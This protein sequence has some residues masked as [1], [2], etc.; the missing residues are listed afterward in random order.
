MDS[1]S[2]E[3]DETIDTLR[4]SQNNHAQPSSSIGRHESST[5]ANIFTRSTTVDV[6][7]RP[8]AIVLTKKSVG[9]FAHHR[10]SAVFLSHQQFASTDSEDS[11]RS[12]STSSS[13]ATNQSDGPNRK[14]AASPDI[15]HHAP[16]SKRADTNFSLL[17]EPEHSALPVRKPAPYRVL[18][19]H[20]SYGSELSEASSTQY[21]TAE[22]VEVCGEEEP[23]EEFR[24][25]YREPSSSH[26][27]AYPPYPPFVHY[28][29]MPPPFQMPPDMWL[30]PPHGE[31]TQ[32]LPAG[33]PGG[34]H[35]CAAMVPM[36]DP[37]GWWVMMPY[38]G[39][40]SVHGADPS[41]GADTSAAAVPASESL[42]DAPRR[43]CPAKSNQLVRSASQLRRDRAHSQDSTPQTTKS[44]HPYGALDNQAERPVLPFHRA[45]P[46]SD[47]SPLDQ[48]MSHQPLRSQHLHGHDQTYDHSN[49][50]T[51]TS[52]SAGSLS[53]QCN[54]TPLHT[55]TS[56]AAALPS[57][58]EGT[59]IEIDFDAF[60]FSVGCT[61]QS[62]FKTGLS[63]IDGG[64]GSGSAGCEGNVNGSVFS[65]QEGSRLFPGL[66]EDL[67]S[68]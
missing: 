14:R 21:S 47:Y 2:E 6:S 33:Y 8:S 4:S 15:S 39:P 7:N 51:S 35:E 45:L 18:S 40:A 5:Q 67:V 59:E 31:F 28:G 66:G 53:V 68:T 63:Y 52:I 10:P 49:L 11:H 42:G 37:F 17:H 50:S 46:P 41:S 9:N 56:A 22:A 13:S 57:V 12:T 34:D 60:D 20:P 55:H 23:S 24:P 43:V 61:P 64:A 3:D 27:E 25:R 54:H 62:A 19:R 44:V 26:T 16:S 36:Q 38:P 30:P 48:P 29:G 58:E 32:C 65:S 1:D